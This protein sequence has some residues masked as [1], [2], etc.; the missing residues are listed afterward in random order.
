MVMLT[1]TPTITQSQ[2]IKALFAQV[3]GREVK[4]LDIRNVTDTDGIFRLIADVK[5]NDA[6]LP[7]STP[8]ESLK[9]IYAMVEQV[10]E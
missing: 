10:I 6:L 7:F 2:N 4:I 1:T 8:L 9:N 5:Y 3:A